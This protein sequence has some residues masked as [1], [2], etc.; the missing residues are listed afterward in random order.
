MTNKTRGTTTPA[1]PMTATAAARVQRATAKAN[2][3]TVAK[4]TFAARAQRAAAKAGKR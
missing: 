3:G 4:D 2:G 1:T